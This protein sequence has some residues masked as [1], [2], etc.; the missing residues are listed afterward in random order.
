MILNSLIELLVKM[1]DE[2]WTLKH[3]ST[4]LLFV[5]LINPFWLTWSRWDWWSA[6]VS[7]PPAPSTLACSPAWRGGPTGCS[8]WPPPPWLSHPSLAPA[9]GAVP[10]CSLCKATPPCFQKYPLIGDCHYLPVSLTLCLLPWVVCPKPGT[11]GCPRSDRWLRYP[12]PRWRPAHDQCGQHRWWGGH[13]RRSSQGQ[14]GPRQIRH[15]PERWGT[16]KNGN[17]IWIRHWK[18]SSPDILNFQLD[19][20]WIHLF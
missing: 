1:S 7:C 4:S 20:C 12:G 6:P 18:C 16:W 19:D 13:R 15:S 11:W 17:L 8:R 5:K 2:G 3:F 14:G 9:T 10:R